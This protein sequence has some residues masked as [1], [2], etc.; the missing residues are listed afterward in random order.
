MK[1][2]IFWTICI[3]II[4]ATGIFVGIYLYNRRNENKEG[5]MN[6][7][8]TTS[9]VADEG[10]EAIDVLEIA[11]QSDKT[12]PNTLM[13]YKIYYTKCKHYINEYKNIDISSVNLTKEEIQERNRE[14]KIEEF[15]SSQ[16]I[17]EKE[18]IGF[19]N[20]HFKLKLID[21]R[22][23]IFII[24]EIGN[25]TEYEIT[26]ITSEYMTEEDILKLKEGILVYGR[27]NLTSVLE[28]YE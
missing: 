15:S 3:C 28:D 4:I 23:V 6:N 5:N 18:E 2:K 20:E 12:T 24:D 17:L 22:I 7:A 11:N 16:I 14:W 26:E 13:I 8:D 10:V 19:C 25:E 21:E 9:D 27:E 1:T